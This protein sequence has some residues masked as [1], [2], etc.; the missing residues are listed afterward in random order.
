MKRILSIGLLIMSTLSSEALSAAKPRKIL[1]A[2]DGTQDNARDFVHSKENPNQDFSNV[3]KLHL[4]AGGSISNERNDIED[5]ICLYKRGLGGE[6][7][8]KLIRGINSLRGK[9]SQQTVPMREM[10]EGVYEEGD[11]LYI[12]GFSRGSA[13]ARAFVADLDESGLKT[14][15]GETVEKPPV[16]FLGCFDTVSD[17]IKNLVQHLENRVSKSITKSSVVGEIDGKLSSIVETAVHNV[18][19]DDNRQWGGV[20]SFP[21]CLMD[22]KDE[23]IHE[24]WFPGEHGDVGGSVGH[25]GLADG[26]LEYMQEWMKKCGFKFLEKGED[27]HPVCLKIPNHEDLDKD[28]DA[29]RMN[30]IP[31]PGQNPNW[32]QTQQWED[33]SYRFVTAVT[34]EEPIPDAT[35]R[36]HKSCLD[37]YEAMQNGEDKFKPINQSLLECKNIVVVG[38]LDE[39]LEDETKKLKALI[40]AANN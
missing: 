7:E 19:M 36:I 34:N 14:A 6:S 11:E 23:R 22:S 4:L 5:Q 39:E 27:I 40:A 31:A 30:I 37:H 28:V 24:A 33:P 13:S 21:P 16:K 32:Q 20:P 10:L 1:L 2:F 38:S 9:L 35:V 3:L 26:S 12:V 18:A 25:K 8:S 29:S 15:R 17:Q